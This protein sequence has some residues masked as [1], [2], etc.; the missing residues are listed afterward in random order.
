MFGFEKCYFFKRSEFRDGSI[1]MREIMERR[2]IRTQYKFVKK[3]RKK[4]NVKKKRFKKNV[5]LKKRFFLNVLFKKHFFL[6][7]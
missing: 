4:K 1:P 2:R 6:K 7:R 5:F 3:I